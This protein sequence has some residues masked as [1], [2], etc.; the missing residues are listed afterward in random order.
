MPWP[1]QSCPSRRKTEEQAQLMNEAMKAKGACMFYVAFFAA[2]VFYRSPS[3]GT[4]SAEGK[5]TKNKLA[6][7]LMS[8]SADADAM[9]FECDCDIPLMK[10]IRA[11]ACCSVLQTHGKRV[12]VCVCDDCHLTFARHGPASV[13][14]VG[15]PPVR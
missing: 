1:S 3:M 5:A 11:A 9:K 4:I 6:Q 2:L 7:T 10:E 12:H 13:V 15:S 14:S 8:I